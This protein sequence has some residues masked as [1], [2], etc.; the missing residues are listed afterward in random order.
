MWAQ[1]TI[2]YAMY[3]SQGRTNPFAGARGDKKAI[4]PF[5][6]FLTTC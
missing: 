6:I 4:W 5:I 2:V 3:G 1:G